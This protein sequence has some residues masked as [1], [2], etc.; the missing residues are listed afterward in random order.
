MDAHDTSTAGLAVAWSRRYP[1]WLGW[2]VAAAGV[3]S[4]AAGLV[5]AVAGEPTALSRV[6]TII[7]PTVITLWLV[8]MNVLV[9]RRAATLERAAARAS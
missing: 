8:E 3:G 6:L 2:V 4:V 7:F 9:L 1:R 5:Q